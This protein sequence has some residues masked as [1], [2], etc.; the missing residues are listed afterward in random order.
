M[1]AGLFAVPARNMMRWLPRV[2]L[3]DGLAGLD[4][5]FRAEVRELPG[6]EETDNLLKFGVS[7]L[8][9]ELLAAGWPTHL[10]RRS[11]RRYCFPN[12]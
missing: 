10:R 4:Q 1:S 5:G 9:K 2:H 8:P 7:P 6:R 3:D 12:L 11:P